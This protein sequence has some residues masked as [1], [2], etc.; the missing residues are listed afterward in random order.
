MQPSM[1]STLLN[2]AMIIDTFIM[3]ISEKIIYR[4]VSKG[5]VHQSSDND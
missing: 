3:Q 5:Q 2:T 1:V 4:K